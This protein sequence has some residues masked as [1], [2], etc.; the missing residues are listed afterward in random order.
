[1]IWAIHKKGHPCEMDALNPLNITI[2]DTRAVDRPLFSG[3]FPLPNR[4]LQLLF[5]Y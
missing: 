2:M 5:P 3:L 1:M 4:Q